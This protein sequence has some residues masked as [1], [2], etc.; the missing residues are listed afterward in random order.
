MFE[1]G[2]A[3]GEAKPLAAL[4]QLW[5]QHGAAGGGS[6][7]CSE[8]VRGQPGLFGASTPHKQPPSPESRL[9]RRQGATLAAAVAAVF[10]VTARDTTRT[11]G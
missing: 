4:L 3:Q 7:R 10:I 6:G 11:L 2:A 8:F 1:A 9:T 5:R